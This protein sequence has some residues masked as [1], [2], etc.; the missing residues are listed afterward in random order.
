MVLERVSLLDPR[1]VELIRRQEE[2]LSAKFSDDD[3]PPVGMRPEEVD[4]GRGAFF[5]AV[6]D[7]VAIACGAVRLIAPDIAEVKRIYTAPEARRRGVARAV[8]A[9]LDDVARALGAR[10]IWVE[11]YKGHDSV[12]MYERAGF[13]PIPPY[14][15]YVHS[16]NSVCLGKS[17]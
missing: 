10:E 1:A 3:D 2:E 8:L 9:A 12:L 6:E 16:R 4:P 14:A 15:E 7:G 17:L 11:T 13:R 5:L